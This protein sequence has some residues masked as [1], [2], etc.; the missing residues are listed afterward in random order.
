MDAWVLILYMPIT[1]LTL[2]V[3]GKN[4]RLLPVKYFWVYYSVFKWYSQKYLKKSWKLD[5]SLQHFFKYFWVCHWNIFG[6]ITWLLNY[7][8]KSIWWEADDNFSQVLKEY[9]S[10]TLMEAPSSTI[11]QIFLATLQQKNWRLMSNFWS[12]GDCCNL[13][14]TY[15]FWFGDK[16][17]RLLYLIFFTNILESITL[18]YWTQMYSEKSRQVFIPGK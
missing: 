13:F 14:S 3:L 12:A 1:C 8:P 9:L 11:L 2:S 6:R 18:R 10:V 17:E 4:C 5:T 7:R 16:V 15:I